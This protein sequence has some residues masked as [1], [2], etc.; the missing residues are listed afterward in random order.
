MKRCFVVL[1]L[2]A[3]AG[4][5]QA[6]DVANGKKLHDE[7]CVSCH[8]SMMNGDPSKIY[9]RS[10][11]KMTSLNAL[12]SQVRFCATSLNVQWFEDELGDVTAY[13]NKEYY[14]FKT[15]KAK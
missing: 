13:L 6:G 9:T 11:H 3:A 14:K 1:T 4:I 12:Q 5:A 2:L 8:K 15:A 7:N 10:D